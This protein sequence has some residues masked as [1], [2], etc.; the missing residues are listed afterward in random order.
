M[1]KVYRT[2]R[3]KSDHTKFL[4]AN[5]VLAELH[6]TDKI[7]GA[8]SFGHAIEWHYFRDSLTPQLVAAIESQF[9]YVVLEQT[10]MVQQV[11]D[12]QPFA[13]S[14]SLAFQALVEANKHGFNSVVEQRMFR[15]ASL[16]TSLTEIDPFAKCR[17][18]I[19]EF[20]AMDERYAALVVLSNEH[21]SMYTIE[22][23][24]RLSEI[25]R[26]ATNLIK[27]IRAEYSNELVKYVPL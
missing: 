1:S 23:L 17:W 3:L 27:R 2:L 9:E 18:V 20:L 8:I 6:T 22:D 26:Q 14:R 13:P 12:P 15:R 16:I 19:G 5:V 7:D 4:L 24:A 11:T 25:E 21:A 10:I